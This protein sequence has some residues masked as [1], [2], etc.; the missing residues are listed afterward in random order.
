MKRIRAAVL[1]AT[2][3]AG[4][5]VAASPAQALS[6][7]NGEAG[8]I[9]ICEYGVATQTAPDGSKHQFLI[10]TD[11]A[12]WTRDASKKGRWSGWY[13]MGGVFT[14]KIYIIDRFS[15]GDPW[16]FTL[17]IRGDDGYQ[18]INIRD[19]DGNWGGWR[20]MPDPD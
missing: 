11:Q 18:W 19:H 10:G 14:D 4:L 20:R 5:V 3:L 1:A 7:C 17:S 9:Y 13:S 15:G 8:A 6:H 12:V 16:V 2:I